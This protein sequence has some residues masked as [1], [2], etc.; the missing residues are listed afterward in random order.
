MALFKVL[1]WVLWT[2]A[3]TGVGYILP[4]VS[5]IA[6]EE[7]YDLVLILSPEVP[8]VDDGLRLNPDREKT[9]GLFQQML[10]EFKNQ[11]PRY[12]TV[13]ITGDSYKGR[14]DQARAAVDQLLAFNEGFLEWDALGEGVPGKFQS[15]PSDG[16]FDSDWAADESIDNKLNWS[17]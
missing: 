7:R 5:A 17:E 3:L 11:T 14:L 9:D 8:W 16:S 10:L 13:F 12:R 6:A 1:P 4:I 2:G 15:A